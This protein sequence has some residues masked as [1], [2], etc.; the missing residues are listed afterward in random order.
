MKVGLPASAF[1]AGKVPELGNLNT[2]IPESKDFKVVYIM[3]PSNPKTTNGGKTMV[4]STDKKADITGEIE[5]IAYALVLNNKD[6]VFVSMDPFTKDLN[7][8]GVP[9]A[10]TKAVFQQKL[11]NMFVKSNVKGVTNGE[12]RMVEILNSGVVTIEQT[13][14]LR[15][16]GDLLQSTILEIREVV[17]L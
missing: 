5:K 15:F 13:I 4:Y 14:H 12:F 3:D 2:F 16:L 1:R 6:Y 7:K 10:A 11:K 8:I 9:T 17:V